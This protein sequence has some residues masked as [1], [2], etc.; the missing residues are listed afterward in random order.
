MTGIRTNV[1]TSSILLRNSRGNPLS[2]KRCMTASLVV[3]EIL[4]LCLLNMS[5]PTFEVMMITVF[6]RVYVSFRVNNGRSTRDYR[7]STSLPCPSVRRPS[8]ITCKNTVQK[9]AQVFSILEVSS[10]SAEDVSINKPYSSSKTMQY[11]DRRTYS[12]SCPPSLKPT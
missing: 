5:A 7:K 10:V 11:G 1:T 3:L 2:L 8:S 6:L 12:V 9:A 4:P